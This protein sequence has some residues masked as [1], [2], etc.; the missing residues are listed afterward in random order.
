M[1]LF[2]C[3][4]VFFFADEALV[5]RPS[6][7]ARL[8]LYVATKIIV[9]AA[10]LIAVFF[11]GAPGFLLLLLPVMVAL[12]AWFGLYS[13]WLYGL[14]RTP[15]AGALLNAAVFAWVIAATFALVA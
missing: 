5:A 13:H 14:T 8:V 2:A 12:F 10:L 15:W 4:F 3:C 11:L 7:R 9:I 6:R 1:V